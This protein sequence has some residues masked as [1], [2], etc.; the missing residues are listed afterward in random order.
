MATPPA[1]QP[2]AILVLGGTGTVGSRVVRQ[3]SGLSDCLILVASRNGEEARIAP[4]PPPATTTTTT[5]TPTTT[6]SPTRPAPVA[7][8]DDS[9]ASNTGSS[10]LRHVLFDWFRRE[11]WDNPFAA[12]AV[13][14]VYLVAPP[15]LD[16]GGLMAAFVDFARERGARRFVLQSASSLEP[17]GPAMGRVHGYLRELGRRGEV[18]WAVLRPSWFQRACVFD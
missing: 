2:A 10:R 11:T 17:G 12:V 4:L 14:A 7:Q 6:T 1:S 8:Q 18:D 13:G 16:A 3:L 15:T 5:P 9:N